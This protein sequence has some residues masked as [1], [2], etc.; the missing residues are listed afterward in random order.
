MQIISTNFAKTLVWKHEYDVKMWRHKQLTPNAN[1]HHMHWMKSPPWKVSAYATAAYRFS[2]SRLIALNGWGTESS[3]DRVHLI[4]GDMPV[5]TTQGQIGHGQ[6]WDSKFVRT[7]SLTPR[8]TNN[9]LH[10][11]HSLQSHTTLVGPIQ[12]QQRLIFVLANGRVK[13][14][15]LLILVIFPNVSIAFHYYKLVTGLWEVCQNKL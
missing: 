11:Y 13:Q 2:I 7:G 6:Q 5:V 10:H 4:H 8:L 9:K 14:R 12:V 3:I 1:D 15:K